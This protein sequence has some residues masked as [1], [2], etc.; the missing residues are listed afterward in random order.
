YPGSRIAMYA[1]IWE[2]A[3]VYE[4]AGALEPSY[5]RADALSG[6]WWLIQPVSPHLRHDDLARGLGLEM[7]GYLPP[8]AVDVPGRVVMA[9]YPREEMEDSRRV[10]LLRDN[11]F[12]AGFQKVSWARDRFPLDQPGFDLVGRLEGVTEESYGPYRHSS[13]LPAWPD[14]NVGSEVK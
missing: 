2:Y 7:A 10:A 4:A 5:A 1:V 13:E 14:D 8:G 3:M 6:E 11:K 9:C 12:V